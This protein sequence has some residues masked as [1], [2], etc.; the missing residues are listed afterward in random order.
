MRLT[1]HTDYAL[2]VLLHLGQN[3][4]RR[5][6]I[7]YI[8]D[9]HG[10][11]HNHLVKVVSHLAHDGIILAHRGRSGGVE[12][13]CPPKDVV[14]GKVVRRMEASLQPVAACT[15][16]NGQ[17]DCLLADI[18]TLRPILSRAL[19]AFLAVLDTVT[20][21]DILHPSGGPPPTGQ[22]ELPTNRP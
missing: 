4:G 17:Q 7:Q 21:H 5:I 1:L 6:P 12:L 18:C 14:I 15:P 22:T 19:D 20:L 16:T 8:A 10:I 9:L 2:R 3:P 11:S 13:A